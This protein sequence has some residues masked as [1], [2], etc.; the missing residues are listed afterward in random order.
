VADA[1]AAKAA[2]AA[3]VQAGVEG[4]GQQRKHMMQLEARLQVSMD[5][6]DRRVKELTEGVL[7]ELLPAALNVMLPNCE[8]QLTE[9][10]PERCRV[11]GLWK[12]CDTAAD[13]RILL[14]LNIS[15]QRTGG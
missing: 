15:L 5:N 10:D 12:A 9:L 1:A 14:P 6:E 4:L 7:Y 8:D 2:A 3:P 11:S 13:F